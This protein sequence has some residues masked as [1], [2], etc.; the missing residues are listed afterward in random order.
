MITDAL[1]A[2][3]DAIPLITELRRDTEANSCLAAPIVERL[4]TTGLCRMALA[5][6]LE[7][8]EV[9]PAAA[10]DVYETLAHCEASASWIV[11]NNALPCLLSRFLSPAERASLFADPAWLYAC[12]TR[13]SGKA[14][15]DGDGY[16][17]DG[18]WALV[19]GCTFSEW[20]LLTCVVVADV[21]PAE[22]RADGPEVRLAY[23]RR[24]E[25]EIVETWDAGG[26]RGTGSHDV[27]VHGRHVGHER[28]ISPAEPSTLD[29]PLG[30][31]PIICTMVA[32]YG[33]Q[34]L[35]IGQAAV[36]TLVDITRTKAPLEGPA[37]KERPQVL[38]SIAREEARLR[39]AREYLHV[40][41]ADLWEIARE[42]RATLEEI[43][44]VWGAALHAVD[45]GRSAVDEMYAAGGTSSLYTSCP[46]ER[47]HRDMHAML[48]HIAGAPFWLEDAARVKLGAAPQHPLYAV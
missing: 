37:L 2:A 40:R 27:I 5:K 33:A 47:E 23:L 38:A 22:S 11:W 14:T 25:Y 24:G 31:I 28:T 29:A 30:R 36:D 20:A 32:W 45:A 8:L 16:R 42:R 1:S 13:P 48:R 26:L 10:L 46:L 43:G 12:S 39:A 6:T 34:A 19:S 4:H 7:G 15:V 18:R 21:E 9:E 35:G 41:L 3:R 44:T 17:I